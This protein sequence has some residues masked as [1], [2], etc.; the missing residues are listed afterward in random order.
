MIKAS[1]DGFT[2]VVDFFNELI[3]VLLSLVR[4]LSLASIESI[5]CDLRVVL[6][7]AETPLLVV[8]F[9]NL[10]FSQLI[11]EVVLVK[12]ILQTRDVAVVSILVLVVLAVIPASLLSEDLQLSDPLLQHARYY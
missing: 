12:A 1:E 5:P 4:E 3:F 6:S 9:A 10:L 2:M 11:I 8:I 7:H